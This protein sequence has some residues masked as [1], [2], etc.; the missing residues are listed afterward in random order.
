MDSKQT[1]IFAA[2]IRL[3]TVKMIGKRGFGHVAGSLSVTDA[4]AVLYGGVMNVKPSE[5]KWEGRDKLVMSKGHAGPALYS[6]LALKGYFPMEWLD[7]LNQPNT[8]L[9][10]HCDAT[11]TPGV[12]FTT[13]SLGQGASAAVG[14]ALA[15]KMDGTDAKT[16]LFLGDGECNEGQVWEAVMFASQHKLSN[17]VTFVD[18]N[19][20][21]LDGT[22]GEVMDMKGIDAKFAEF[23]WH[24]QSIDGNN[25]SAVYDALQNLSQTLPNAIILNTKKGAGVSVVENTE[26]NHHMVVEGDLLAN[27]LAECEATLL[28]L[29]K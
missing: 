25:V 27:A 18:Y 21:Q 29:T 10:S 28:E 22:T 1:E 9:P 20:K 13:G 26:M 5:P 19:G 4:L 16:Y 2:Q 3:E 17:L 11:L 12:D 23:G 24:A 15:Q 7:T 8:K 6:A 14:F